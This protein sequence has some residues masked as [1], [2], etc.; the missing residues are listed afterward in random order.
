MI[1]K[2]SL[3][4]SALA[5]LSETGRASDVVLD[6]KLIDLSRRT[7]ELA[8]EL[9]KDDPLVPGGIVYIDEPDSALFL[10]EDNYC[11]AI[12]RGTTPNIVDWLQNLN[13]FTGRVCSTKHGDCCTTRLG[14]QQAYELPYYK[15]E[16]ESNVRLCKDECKDC[17]VIFAGHSQ[18]GAIASIA[19]IA[20]DDMDPTILAFGQPGSIIGDCPSI[21]TDNYYRFV[22]TV[23]DG[24]NVNYDPVPYLNLNSDHRGHL[25]VM[26]ASLL[27]FADSMV[28]SFD[29]DFLTF[30]SLSV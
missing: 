4:L 21:N 16:L 17:Q 14:F 19:A 28:K 2:F 10:R 5:F 6:E 26:G 18:G 29:V 27:C 23:L 15:D 7:M 3:L 13:P 1:V 12:F 30:C 24:R 25:F 20:M 11:F 9:Q 8:A 22:N